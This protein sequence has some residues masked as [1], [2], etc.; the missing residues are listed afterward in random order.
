[1]DENNGKDE[2]KVPTI[3]INP[4][5]VAMEVRMILTKEG[6]AYLFYPTD[7]LPAALALFSKSLDVLVGIVRRTLE[8]Q[9]QRRVI[10][11][12]QAQIPT[13]LKLA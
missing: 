5:D 2:L 10:P 11:V 3:N 8:E 12:T 9:E 7:N 6:K 1:M 13:G 4:E